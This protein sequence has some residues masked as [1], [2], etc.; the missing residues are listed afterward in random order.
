[1][2]FCIG[3]DN[4]NLLVI[5]ESLLLL[6]I[7]ILN[8]RYMNERFKVMVI[9]KMEHP[10]ILRWLDANHI[11][12]FEDSIPAQAICRLIELNTPTIAFVRL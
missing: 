4:N 3:S 6:D 1:M 12:F 9:G 5:D 11:A 10:N 2:G 7:N 8:N